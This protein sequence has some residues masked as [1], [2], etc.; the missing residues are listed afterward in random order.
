MKD[1]CPGIIPRGV[2]ELHPLGNFDRA[3]S[4][5]GASVHLPAGGRA[6][7]RAQARALFFVRA[8]RARQTA[9]GQ[10]KQAAG[11]PLTSSA[12]VCL[13]EYLETCR[14]ALR[15]PLGTPSSLMWATFGS[16]R[17]TVPS[18]SAPG[19]RSRRALM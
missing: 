1:C 18:T 13:Q 15:A 16:T 4:G 17:L 11:P 2:G 10:P 19:F 3:V 7:G 9:P 5:L 6:A 12:R 14:C 8:A